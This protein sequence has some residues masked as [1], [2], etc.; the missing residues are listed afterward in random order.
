[1]PIGMRLVD[2]SKA[3]VFIGLRNQVYNIYVY[4]PGTQVTLDFGWTRPCLGGLTFKNGGHWQASIIQLD[5]LLSADSRDC[6][7]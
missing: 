4:I 5:Q 2:L 6:L 7:A 1:M 3:F